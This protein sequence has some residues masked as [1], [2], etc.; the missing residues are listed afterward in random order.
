MFPHSF[1]SPPAQSWM[2]RTP[3]RR[4]QSCRRRWSSGRTARRRTETA[5]RTRTPRSWRLWPVS[6]SSALLLVFSCSAQSWYI[7]FRGPSQSVLCLFDFQVHYLLPGGII[8]GA[9]SKQD[10]IFHLRLWLF[11]QKWGRAHVKLLKVATL[12]WCYEVHQMTRR[13]ANGKKK[14]GLLTQI[15]FPVINKL[16]D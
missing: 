13:V 12:W 3:T 6:V 2:S 8:F 15:K 7:S 9:V 1:F 10:Y 5:R 16:K 4:R 11:L 14:G